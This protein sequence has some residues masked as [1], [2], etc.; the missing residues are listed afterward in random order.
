MDKEP[1]LLVWNYT[2][3]EKEK[4]DALLKE[5]GAPPASAID[6]TRGH[7]SLRE[8]IH[9]DA[10]GQDK[11]ES[12][13][14]VLLFYNIPEKGVFLLINI[15]KKTDLPHPIYAVVTKHSIEW[16][17]SKLLEHLISERDNAEKRTASA[18]PCSNTD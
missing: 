10:H 13:E 5:I 18:G 9:T 6:S 16:P 2:L 14:K 17:F 12:D 8:I 11:L 3:E 7:L 15:F 1:R 4:L